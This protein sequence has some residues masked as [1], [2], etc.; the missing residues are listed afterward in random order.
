MRSWPY[1]VGVAIFAASYYYGGWWGLACFFS[2]CAGW[3]LCWRMT[4]GQWMEPV[5]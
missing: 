3:H 2:F 5:D 1:Y 4:K